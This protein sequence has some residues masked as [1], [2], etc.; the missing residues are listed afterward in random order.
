MLRILILLVSLGCRSNFTIAT[1]WSQ[2]SSPGIFDDSYMGKCLLT[3]SPKSSFVD[4][5]GSRF[6]LSSNTDN[7]CVLNQE[8]NVLPYISYAKPLVRHH[9]SKSVFHLIINYSPL[10]STNFLEKLVQQWYSSTQHYINIFD[11]TLSVDF[12]I[13]IHF[14]SFP[15]RLRYEYDEIVN[16]MRNDIKVN[17]KRDF[18]FMSSSS[19][20]HSS[21]VS[22]DLF[23]FLDVVESPSHVLSELYEPS[24]IDNTSLKKTFRIE[25]EDE[26]ALFLS[27]F[28]GSTVESR[29][30][31]IPEETTN[32]EETYL[33]WIQQVHSFIETRVLPIS[34]PVFKESIITQIRNISYPVSDGDCDFFAVNSSSLDFSISSSNDTTSEFVLLLNQKYIIWQQYVNLLEH[35]DKLET[36]SF[37]LENE[38]EKEI[39][40]Y[41]VFI[42]LFD[43]RL[44]AL[45]REASS[46]KQELSVHLERYK[47]ESEIEK[48]VV[49]LKQLRNLS[50]L[51][52]R[53]NVRYISW[54]TFSTLYLKNASYYQQL[55]VI[56]G[57]LLLPLIVPVFRI[58]KYLFQRKAK[59]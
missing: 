25:Y 12:S 23:C 4:C 38:E 40:F 50:E 26:S 24:P 47:R 56:F 41:S 8:F 44:F 27:L 15:S 57:T 33:F 17:N 32:H 48:G 59:S 55:L 1:L 6:V 53:L 14:L 37:D 3:I 45:K 42:H 21:I 11:R 52:E 39:P 10:S 28:R 30:A 22:N 29:D 36:T 9:H 20:S 2:I 13:K 18:Y 54:I 46:L 58:M 43:N 34:V 49:V 31:M 5:L 51:F 7:Q 16:S 19:P 35:E